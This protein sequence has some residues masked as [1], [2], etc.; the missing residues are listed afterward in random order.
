MGKAVYV[1]TEPSVIKYYVDKS[2]F[3]VMEFTK[4]KDLKNLNYWLDGS[5]N[6]TFNQLM[7]LSKKLQVPLGYLVVKKPVDDT[8]QILNYRTIDSKDMDHISRNLIETIKIVKNQQEF[9]LDYRKDNGF[10][11]LDYVAKYTIDDDWNIIV[12]YARK[13]LGIGEEWQKDLGRLYP[14]KYF[15]KKLNDIGVVIQSNGIVRQNTHRKLDISEFRAFVSIDE[16][17]PFVF[18]NTND[19]KNGQLFSLLHEFGHILLGESEVYNV[20][21]TMNTDV[22]QLERI[23]NKIASELL[24]PNIIFVESW[25]IP[26]DVELYE[27]VTDLAKKFKVSKTVIARKALDNKLIKIED[28]NFIAKRNVEE[29]NKY[30]AIAKEQDNNGIDYYNTIQSKVDPILFDSVKSSYYEGNIQYIEALNLLNIGSKGFEFL[31][32]K[33][34]LG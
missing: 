24:I 13:I 15:K 33:N 31:S 20:D 3:D 18:I 26:S 19:T 21:L 11:P 34:D 25:N 32:N 5:K 9:L 1:E 16:Y 23:C 2:E 30:Q 8:P 27:Y 17:A 4:E 29:Y 28:Y 14:L 10:M 6:P 7:K 12:Q 22:N